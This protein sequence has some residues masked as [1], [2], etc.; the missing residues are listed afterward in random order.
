MS[1]KSQEKFLKRAMLG[2]INHTFS[3]RQLHFFGQSKIEMRLFIV[4]TGCDNASNA[5]RC[6]DSGRP[7]R[8]DGR[9]L[10]GFVSVEFSLIV[11]TLRVGWF[12]ISGA[13][14]RIR[15]VTFLD[16]TRFCVTKQ[17]VTSEKCSSDMI[18]PE[19]STWITWS[20]CENIFAQRQPLR[21]I[22]GS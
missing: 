22:V 21:Q 18:G 14:I 6:E 1:F 4:H 9:P 12:V 10:L 15:R 20:Y 19:S 8:G 16:C 2:L 3:L 13:I 11:V 5:L 7:S 17:D